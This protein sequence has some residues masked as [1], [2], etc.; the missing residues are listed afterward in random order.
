MKEYVYLAAPYSCGDNASE[1]ERDK[2]FWQ[3][4]AM[5]AELMKMGYVVFSPITHC[6]LL[7]EF[8]LA[9]SHDWWLELDYCYLEGASGLLVLE[10]EGWQMSPGV[11]GEIAF[12][13]EHNIPI[14]YLKPDAAVL[15]KGLQVGGYI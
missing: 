8:G 7:T 11:R 13:K 14:A 10:M 6:H 4:T 15:N 5:T 2:R 12:A 3:I 1:E 9:K